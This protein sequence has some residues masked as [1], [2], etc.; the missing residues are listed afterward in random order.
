MQIPEFVDGLE[1]HYPR[2][3]FTVAD[4]AVYLRFLAKTKLSGEQLLTLFDEALTRFHYFPLIAELSDLRAELFPVAVAKF[5]G[6]AWEP[7]PG[8][9]AVRYTP[10]YREYLKNTK[11]T[12]KTHPGKQRRNVGKPQK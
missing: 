7:V 5:T 1:N 2:R 12:P 3:R 9:S 10:A 4:R 6:R 8:T 11:R